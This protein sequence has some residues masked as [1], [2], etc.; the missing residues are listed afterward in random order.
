VI[1]NYL[2][3]L[4]F[5]PSPVPSHDAIKKLWHNGCVWTFRRKFGVDPKFGKKTPWPVT[6]S[7]FQSLDKKSQKL[8]IRRLEAI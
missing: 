7:F 3:R 6:A 2:V 8:G 1:K 4:A 5:L